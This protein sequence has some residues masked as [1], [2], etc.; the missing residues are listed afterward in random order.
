MIEY[1]NPLKKYD[2]VDDLDTIFK[3]IESCNKKAIPGAET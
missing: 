1:M 3:D 2:V